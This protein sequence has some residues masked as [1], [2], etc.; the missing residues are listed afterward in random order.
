MVI[1][2]LDEKYA[3]PNSGLGTELSRD[4]RPWAA[5]SD[6][7]KAKFIFARGAAFG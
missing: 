1:L 7:Y 2:L 4:I 6:T 5:F 3:D